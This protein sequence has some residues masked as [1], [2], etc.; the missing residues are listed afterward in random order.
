MKMSLSQNVGEKYQSSLKK[1]KEMQEFIDHQSDE[2]KQLRKI[3]EQ[4]K[5]QF[6]ALEKAYEKE[7]YNLKQSIF[8]LKTQLQH[9]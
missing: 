4:Q 1:I 7:V 8:E 9:Q 3:I 2:K 6:V 5:Y